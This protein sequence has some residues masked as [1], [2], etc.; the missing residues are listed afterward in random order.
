MTIE[1]VDLTEKFEQFDD[2]WRPRIVGRLNGQVVKVAKLRGEF[3]WH[4]HDDEDEMFL[5]VHGELLLKFRD[6]DV[7][8]EPGE[9]LIVPCG[10]EHKPVAAEEVHVVLF[11]P[12]ST[13][14]TGNVRDAHTVD[15]EETL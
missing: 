14:N 10:V 9:F 3:I 7:R 8:L 15:V 2:H 12:A 5:V 11:E 1:K 6:R 4:H 13:V